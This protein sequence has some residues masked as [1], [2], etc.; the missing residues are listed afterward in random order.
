M[1]YQLQTYLRIHYKFFLKNDQEHELNVHKFRNP[2]TE[3]NKG[4]F[5][6]RILG[7][8]I[9]NMILERIDQVLVVQNYNINKIYVDKYDLWLGILTVT[10]IAI[11][12]T[13]N[14]LKYYCPR[15]LLF[16]SDIILLIKHNMDW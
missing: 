14:R 13:S 1:R 3:K 4:L 11:R 7:N 8:C 2:L 10:E 15:Q 6:P 12:S 16:V 5:K 9:S